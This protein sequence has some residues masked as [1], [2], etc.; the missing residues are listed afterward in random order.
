MPETQYRMSSRLHS[1]MSLSYHD[2]YC[3]ASALL[4]SAPAPR[5]FTTG[6]HARTLGAVVLYVW[7]WPL[8]PVNYT[9]ALSVHAY[10]P[11][12]TGRPTH[13][14][15]ERLD[16]GWRTGLDDRVLRGRKFTD[17]VEPRVPSGGNLGGVEVVLR[18]S[19]GLVFRCEST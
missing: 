4:T 2:T 12:E 14:L 13:V 7:F 17:V 8:V 3:V 15:V 10:S 9:Q 6:S 18:R 19:S 11:K 5:A 1:T 16:P